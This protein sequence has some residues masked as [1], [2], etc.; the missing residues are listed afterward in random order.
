MS[1]QIKKIKADLL[2]ER[3][4]SRHAFYE[5]SLHKNSFQESATL[6]F[7]HIQAD[8][9][10]ALRAPLYNPMHEVDFYPFIYR[11]IEQLSNLIGLIYLTFIYSALSLFFNCLIAFNLKEINES[12]NLFTHAGFALLL[13]ILDI[14]LNL[15]L[16]IISPF[17]RSAATIYYACI[18]EDLNHDT[19]LLLH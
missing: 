10:F 17:T 16:L 18:S 15:S 6:F 2:L 9:A 7:N 5:S 11:L 1:F 8:V 4:N 12:F 14:I 19:A 13:V 3:E